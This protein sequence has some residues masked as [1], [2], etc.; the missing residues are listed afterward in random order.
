M[1]VA[2][3]DIECD[4]S[5]GD[6][7][8]AKKNYKKLSA[9]LLDNIH[10]RFKRLEKKNQK[11]LREFLSDKENHQKIVRKLIKLAFVQESNNEEIS[12]C[13]T[14]DSIK[15]TDKEIDNILNR[16]TDI[17]FTRIVREENYKELR[18]AVDIVKKIW[19]NQSLDL[20][21]STALTVGKEHGIPRDKILRR[22][23][24]RDILVEKMTDLFEDHFPDLEGD[25][26]IQI[27]STINR[28]GEDKCFLK[29]IITLDT[30]NKIEG[31]V[32]IPCKTEKEVIIEWFK[33]I[34]ELD[35]DIV[36]GY[37]IF[38][39]DYKF[40]FIR[41]EELNIL[42]DCGT[43]SRMKSKGLRLDEKN[44][45]SS[46]LGEN[47]LNYINMEGRVNMDLL[48]IV[49]KDHKLV[50]YKLDNDKH[51]YKMSSQLV[52]KGTLILRVRDCILGS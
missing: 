18:E 3:F 8:L 2:S 22:I 24:T 30:C 1:L 47:I 4:S 39:F 50:S 7:P 6:F 49:Q 51:V 25:K 48:K 42:D 20:L 10:N 28:Y 29:H 43:L 26:V 9:E 35:P 11:E 16:I 19:S 40:I 14:K 13:Y 12:Y 32:V 27:G 23:I 45:S 33:F 5:H 44:L 34:R 37:N 41:A 15:P 38:G 31:A 21:K 46:A 36:T 17:L 52:L